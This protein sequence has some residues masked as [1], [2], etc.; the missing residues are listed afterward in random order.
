MNWR[1]HKTGGMKKVDDYPLF[2]IKQKSSQQHYIVLDFIKGKE[3]Y[4][5]LSKEGYNIIWLR[6]GFQVET[7]GYD[8]II[9]LNPPHS[10]IEE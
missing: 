5:L 1:F 2:H 3:S 4:L 10:K 7:T 8:S 9:A 6:W